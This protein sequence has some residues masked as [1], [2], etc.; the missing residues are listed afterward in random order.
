[1]SSDNLKEEQVNDRRETSHGPCLWFP[2][3]ST[4]SLRGCPSD[5][6]PGAKSS[7]VDEH[8]CAECT[9]DEPWIARLHVSRKEDMEEAYSAHLERFDNCENEI[10]KGHIQGGVT[11]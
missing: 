1:M 3:S 5:G 2:S 8:I 11:N 9:E 7:Y 4:S 10:G 6:A